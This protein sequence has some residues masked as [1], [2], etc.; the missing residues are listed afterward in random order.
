MAGE[1]HHHQVGDRVVASADDAEPVVDVELP[2]GSGDAADLAAA[3]SLHDEA[4]A[5]CR[6]Q[7][8]SP[9]PPVVGRSHPLAQG[10]L[11]QER[12]E[13]T[14]AAGRAGAADHHQVASRGGGR[15]VSPEEVEGPRPL[16]SAGFACSAAAAEC[17][18]PGA[19]VD[20]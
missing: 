3:A 4:P 6:R 15:V 8:G 10:L 5:T 16:Q 20:A 17:R 2:L 9:R 14:G 13:R 12:R 1:A 11:A 7:G 19:A 18:G